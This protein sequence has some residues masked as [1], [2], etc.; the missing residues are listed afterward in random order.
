MRSSRG[1]ARSSETRCAIGGRLSPGGL[2]APEPRAYAIGRYGRIP[3]WRLGEILELLHDAGQRACP[4]RLTV[5]EWT[6]RSRSAAAFDRFMAE[7]HG[8]R[9]GSA[10]APVVHAATPVRH[11][12]STSRTTNL[13]FESSTRYREE[14]AGVQT[15][16]RY[17]VRDGE[18]WVVWDADWGAVTDET[19]QEGGPPSS[20]P[21]LSSSTR[22]RLVGAYRLEGTGE[23]EVAG[24]RR[25][26]SARGPAPGSDGATAV[27]F[28]LGAGADAIEL[29]IDAERGALLRAEARLARR[30]LPPDRGDGHRVRAPPRGHL[31]ARRSRPVSSPPGGRGP[32]VFRSTSS[33]VPRR[34]RCSH[35]LASPTAGASPRASFT[36]GARSP[37]CRGRGV[38]PVREPGRRVRASASASEP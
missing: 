29:A 30:G 11:P 21:T 26:S 28:S 13:A 2:L 36:R 16:Q 5:V 37:G 35:R 34:F 32:S 18:R 8:G 1:V 14:S 23:F 19:E 7:R 17:Q 25:T 31:P 33:R 6:H 9:L 38:P 20:R 3:A 27:V 10:S 4:A 15:G 22:W 24:T 12:T